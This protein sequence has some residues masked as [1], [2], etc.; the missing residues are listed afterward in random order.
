MERMDSLIL[1]Q[2]ELGNFVVGT[3]GDMTAI[4]Y[5]KLVGELGRYLY[6]RVHTSIHGQ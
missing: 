5:G 1:G 6:F 2:G 4:I 3:N